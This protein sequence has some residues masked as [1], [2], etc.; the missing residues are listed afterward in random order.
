MTEH[1]L[2]NTV[3]RIEVAQSHAAIAAAL[4]D[5]PST[6]TSFGDGFLGRLVNAMSEAHAR[7][8]D[9]DAPSNEWS[10]SQ[11]I[12]A[13]ESL[14]RVV[15]SELETH[16]LMRLAGAAITVAEQQQSRP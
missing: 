4:N 9:V 3:L 10:D 11:I 14:G 5:L 7:L 16:Q 13:C 12:A 6:S 2:L 1:E 15:M 8:R